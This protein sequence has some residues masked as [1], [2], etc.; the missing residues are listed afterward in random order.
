MEEFA[1]LVNFKQLLKQMLRLTPD[2]HPSI[3]PQNVQIV[4]RERCGRVAG[5]RPA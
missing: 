1:F 5:G 4:P 3:A 2:P